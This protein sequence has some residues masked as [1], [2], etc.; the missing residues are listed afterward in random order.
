M[1][2]SGRFFFDAETVPADESQH[3]LLR[4][5]FDAKRAKA[6][7]KAKKAVRERKEPT[8]EEVEETFQEFV[9]KTSFDGNFGRVVAVAYAL[10]DGEVVA[11]SGTETEILEAFWAAYAGATRMIGHNI[12]DFDLPF[13]VRRSRILGV[14]PSALP[15]LA[16]YRHDQVY[17][18]LHEWNLWSGKAGSLDVLARLLGLPTSKDEMSGADVWPYFQ[19]GRIAEICEYCKKDVALTR[20]VYKKMT[21]N[22]TLVTG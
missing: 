19:A 1:T 9:L 4:E 22:D 20:E 18:T 17:D 14:K 7:E 2:A 3:A 16:R 11:L 8:E 10:D 5:V 21:F 6:A 15:N 13:L 12:R